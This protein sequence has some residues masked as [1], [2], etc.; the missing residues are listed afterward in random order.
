MSD[1][2]R[3]IPLDAR[4]WR[5][6]MGLRPLEESKWIEV[7]AHRDEELALKTALLA[8]QRDVVVATR[9]EG[10]EASAEL[11]EEIVGNLRTY[12]PSLP[13]EVDPDEHPIVAAS[14]L[15][16]ED[17]CVLVR[18]DQWR[19]V[20]ASVCFPSRWN[21][22]DK[23]GT[24]MDE[25]H[26][27]VPAYD[28]ELSQPTN[29]LFE[30]LKPERS[31]WRLNW[32]LLDSP[33]LHQPTATRTSPSGRLEDWSFRVER[34]TLRRLSRTGG[35]VFTIRT[36]VESL[37]VLC[38]SDE[39]F[40]VNLLHALDTAPSSMQRYKGWLGVHDYLRTILSS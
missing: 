8:D 30:R 32:T 7:D 6:A 19:L 36:Y 21:L 3:Y 15:V 34:Q 37:D 24:T 11:L 22:A 29:A 10:D 2:V 31:F 26:V 17:L 14:R 5:L 39:D 28:D 13:R 23:I 20:A 35:V 4:G 18:S 33:L 38:R 9:P 16:Q 25:I 1:T 40:S 27:P 12:H